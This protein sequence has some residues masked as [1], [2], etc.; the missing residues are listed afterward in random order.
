MRKLEG[1]KATASVTKN[2]RQDIPFVRAAG[3]GG[4]KTGLPEKSI[5]ELETAWAPLMKWLGYEPALVKPEAAS[6][7]RV[8]AFA[9]GAPAR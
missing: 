9:P 4:W 8:Q 7:A 6:E 1:S 3:S 5:V 2:T